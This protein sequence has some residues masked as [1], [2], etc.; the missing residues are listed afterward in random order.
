M[1]QEGETSGAENAAGARHEKPCVPQ[2]LHWQHLASRAA[3]A[4]ALVCQELGELIQWEA[5]QTGRL[6]LVS[7]P[8]CSVCPQH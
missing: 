7:L 3:E 6:F 2:G 8:L 4:L 5:A 1:W